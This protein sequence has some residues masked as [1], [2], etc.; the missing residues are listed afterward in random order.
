MKNDNAT[1]AI[2]ANFHALDTLLRQ[3]AERVAEGSQYLD[4]GNNNAAIGAVLGLDDTLQDA[5]AL[6]RAILTLHRSKGRA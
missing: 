3:A 1:A 5:H 6:Y 2:A 4:L